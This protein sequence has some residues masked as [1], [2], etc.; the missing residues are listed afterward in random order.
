MT[1]RPGLFEFYKFVGVTAKAQTAN[2]L[3][4]NPLLVDQLKTGKKKSPVTAA[5]ASQTGEF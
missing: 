2:E 3:R 1:N 4:V 5:D